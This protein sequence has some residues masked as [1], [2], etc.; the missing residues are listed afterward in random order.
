MV[1]DTHEQFVEAVL[2]GRPVE[3][4]AV[5]PY[6]DGRVLTGRQ[7][8]ELGLVDELGNINVALEK[9]AE[10]AGLPVVPDQ[11]FEPKR[12]RKG[13]LPLLFGETGAETLSRLA[14]SIPESGSGKRLQLW[15]AF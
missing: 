9:A 15:R 7:A 4:G 10:L 2:A 12:E 5:R 8:H 14:E 13:L 1:L 3:E 6:F 11:I